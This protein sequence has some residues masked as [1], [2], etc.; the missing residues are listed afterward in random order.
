MQPGG[1]QIMI[2]DISFYTAGCCC[3]LEAFAV[4]GGKW[5]KKQ[6]PALFAVIK[7]RNVGNI[8]FDTGYSDHFY[9]A[10]NTFP[11]KLY[12]WTLPVQLLSNEKAVSILGRDNIKS[13]E[14]NHIILSH[15]HADHIAG[16]KDFPKAMLHALEAGF[17]Q[18]QNQKGLSAV[19][20]GLLKTLLPEDAAYRMQFINT[21]QK[22]A[23]PKWMTPF[24]FGYDI[25]ND[26]SLMAIDLPGHALGHMGILVNYKKPYFLVADACWDRKAFQDLKFPSKCVNFLM[27]DV[28][29]YTKTIQ[30]L[31]E[32]HCLNPDLA[33]IPS[34]CA[35]SINEILNL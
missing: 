3:Q 2:D 30:Q 31:H 4:K 33:I 28:K 16:I 1:R 9:S 35:A 11:N 7:H 12:R 18:I 10:T 20:K 24:K 8:L 13:N 6:F 15:F 19:S 17:R 22:C 21:A 34:H 23:L 26:G 5:R 14:I 32:L 27:A 29:A 25:F